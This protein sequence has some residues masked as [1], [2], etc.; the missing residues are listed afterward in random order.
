MEAR[1]LSEEL[2][3]LTLEEIRAQPED[4]ARLL[5]EL[6]KVRNPLRGRSAVLLIGCGSQFYLGLT[7]AWVMRSLLGLEA[8][9]APASEF[10]TFPKVY[11]P[12]RQRS[13]VILVSRSGQTT[14]V[15]EACERA[16][17]MGLGTLFLGAVEDAPLASL[18][19]E[20][21][22]FP[23][24][25][26]RS[27]VTTR[28]TSGFLIALLWWC[29]ERAERGKARE[30]QGLAEAGRAV[31]A[32]AEEV[33][34]ALAGALAPRAIAFL[35][36]GP[37]YGL[38]REAALKSNEMALIPTAAFHSLEYRHGP[39]SLAARDVLVTGL[40]SQVSELTLLRE[41]GGMGGRTLAIGD[42][43]G[44]GDGV[45]WSVSLECE[46]G[47]LARLP[48]YLL[49]VQNLGLALSRARGLNADTPRHLSRFVDLSKEKEGG[50][51]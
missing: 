9:A 12:R 45:E 38:A 17:E 28:A 18:A 25:N 41:L 29:L 13:L 8:E 22:V 31:E 4:W 46:L 27:I 15:V 35:G 39:K 19:H 36:C 34:A 6:P 26:E 11:R 24:V 10:L 49:A 2:G 50:Q 44:E 16:K 42:G 51:R 21:V 40:V 47:R 5:E 32:G 23:Y 43:S 33:A 20:S 48:L 3:R 37:L 30:L 1:R 7:A 14:E